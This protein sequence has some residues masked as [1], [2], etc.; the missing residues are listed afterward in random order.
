MAVLIGAIET[1]QHF[2]TQQSHS[3]NLLLLPIS[4]DI[5]VNVAR[6]NLLLKMHNAIIAAPSTPFVCL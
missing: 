4:A 3:C 2:L 6:P 1:A 5:H